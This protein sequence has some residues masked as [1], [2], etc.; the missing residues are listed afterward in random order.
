MTITLDTGLPNMG[1]EQALRGLENYE[2]WL[3]EKLQELCR[4]LAEIG[5]DYAQAEFSG[6][7]LA[8]D[9]NDVQISLEQTENGYI[10]HAQGE[11][12]AFIEFGAGDYADTTSMETDDGGEIWT[13][14]DSWS[15]DHAKE[16]HTKGRWYHKGVRYVGLMPCNCMSNTSDYI[17]QQIGEIAKEVF[18]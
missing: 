13:Y 17:R 11:S 15:E 16:Y 8:Q 1:I 4:R 10:I 18:S 6:V 14:P 7:E 12:V 5:Q 9:D 2:K 3:N